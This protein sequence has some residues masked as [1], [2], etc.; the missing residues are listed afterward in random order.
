MMI[1]RLWLCLAGFA[2]YLI[3]KQLLTTTP[4]PA[5][6]GISSKLMAMPA[7]PEL[8]SIE[9]VDDTRE[10]AGHGGQQAGHRSGFER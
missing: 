2:A 1:F 10:A 4:L 7:G 8:S 3:A 5:P 6:R 9:A